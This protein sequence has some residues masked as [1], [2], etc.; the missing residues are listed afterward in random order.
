MEV[1]TSEQEKYQSWKEKVNH[2]ML[3]SRYNDYCA[4]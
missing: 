2:S 1:Q 3:S 4:F